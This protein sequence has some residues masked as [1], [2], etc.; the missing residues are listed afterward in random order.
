MA[1]LGHPRPYY[2]LSDIA[3]MIRPALQLACAFLPLAMM[4]MSAERMLAR[5]LR[6]GWQQSH[7]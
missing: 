1:I 2:S 4:S 6:R 7:R 5:Y 3:C